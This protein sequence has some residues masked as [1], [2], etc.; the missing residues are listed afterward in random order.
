V[1]VRAA[2][3]KR[4]AMGLFKQVKQTKGT[5][6]GV[7]ARQPASAPPAPAHAHSAAVF[8]AARAGAPADYAPIAEVSIELYADISRGLATVGHDLSRGP[9]IAARHGVS[10]DR[11]E[12]AVAGW[13]DRIRTSPDV[14]SRF[15]AL[16]IERG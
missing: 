6:T 7:Q 9:E 16:Y 15:N 1:Q 12:T 14:A 5:A 8:A 3:D 13:N 2:T 10:A 4:E 11:W